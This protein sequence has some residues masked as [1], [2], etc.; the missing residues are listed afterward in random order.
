MVVQFLIMLLAYIPMKGVNGSLHHV[1]ASTCCPP[2]FLVLAIRTSEKGYPTIVLICI[3]LII[4][5]A[6]HISISLLAI[7]CVPLGNSDPFLAHF[8]TS[9]F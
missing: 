7:L 8:K 5:D 1:L 2:S 9:W 6:E 4:S 3:S